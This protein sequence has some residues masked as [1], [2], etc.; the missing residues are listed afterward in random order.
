[1]N[2]EEIF[3]R[4]G[5]IQTWKQTQQVRSIFLLKYGTKLTITIDTGAIL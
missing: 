4:V 3:V 5:I 2:P 1:M